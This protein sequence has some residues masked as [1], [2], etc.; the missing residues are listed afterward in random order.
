MPE[1][2]PTPYDH[3]IVSGCGRCGSSLVMQML[4]AGRGGLTPHA[5]HTVSYEHSDIWRPYDEWLPKLGP[6]N[7]VKL[8]CPPL[9]PDNLPP[10]DKTIRFIWLNRS[11]YQQARS[12]HKFMRQSGEHKGLNVH[13]II[14]D[15]IRDNDRMPDILGQYWDCLVLHFESLIRNPLQQAI[16]IATFLNDAPLL[17]EYMVDPVVKNRPTDCLP[18]MLEVELVNREVPT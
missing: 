1:T 10:K 17:P 9:T 7:P 3:I 13:K 5:E 2:L 4:A 18:Y 12:I 8:L 14:K 11:P 15:I 6:T 16:A